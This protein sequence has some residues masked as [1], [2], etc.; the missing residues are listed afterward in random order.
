MPTALKC[1]PWKGAGWRAVEAQHKNA[2]MILV[3]GNIAD[4]AL[5][6]AIIEE[7][8]PV[9]P[10]GAE[11]LHYLLA[12]PF[13]Y[14][15][16]KPGG[17]RFC[18]TT[19]RTS[20]FYGAEDEKTSCAEFGYWRLQMW[21][22][23]E[24]LRGKDT[25]MQVTLFEFHAT[26]NRMLDLASPP[27]SKQMPSWTNKTD[28]CATQA[29]ATEAREQK[30]EAIRSV[31]VR[32]FPEGRCLIMLTPDVFKAANGQLRPFRQKMQTWNLYLA[33]PFRAVW[34]REFSDDQFEFNFAP[35]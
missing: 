16:P 24:G 8:K 17:S 28:Y 12:T 32:N 27:Y 13:R 20:V 30:I 31:S 26:T 10:G 4:Q 2:T 35:D 18:S 29:L 9:L 5:L 6:E 1:N 23:S 22:D 15:P 25:T 3:N 19:E 21:M 14:P 7:E 11:E 33:P 34:T